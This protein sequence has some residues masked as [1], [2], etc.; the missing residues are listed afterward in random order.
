MNI[1]G[2]N[3]TVQTAR[4]ENQKLIQ[5]RLFGVIRHPYY[6]AVILEL[7]GLSFV[8]NSMWVF[9]LTLCVQLPFLLFRVNLE[10]NILVLQFGESYKQYRD[11]VDMFIPI[12]MLFK[13]RSCR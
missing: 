8:F 5:D 12:K 10:E 2:Y 9:M 4:I 7:F 6:L 3:W 11:R 1:L 13:N